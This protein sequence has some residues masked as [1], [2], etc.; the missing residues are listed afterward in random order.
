[1]TMQH[2]HQMGLEP[3]GNFLGHVG[4]G[5]ALLVW[6]IPWLVATTRRSRSGEQASLETSP[7]IAWVKLAVVPIGVLAHVPAPPTWSSASIAMAW[8]HAT[9]FVPFGLSGI[10][11]LL[12]RARR[13]EPQASFG[14]CATALLVAGLLVLGHGNPPGVEGTAHLLLGI[15]FVIGG[16][17]AVLECTQYAPIGRS[18]R[19]GGVLTAA[20]WLLVTAWLLYRSGWDLADHTNVMWTYTLFSW[21]VMVSAIAV[22]TAASIR[23]S[24]GRITAG[25]AAGA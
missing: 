4:P 14:V 18:L 19:I 2:A 16:V 8:Q 11:D 25:N 6:G 20:T 23:I 5:L 12:V 15:S 17:G 21:C 24:R 22:V 13:L 3:T 10:V 1:M 7:W 9:M